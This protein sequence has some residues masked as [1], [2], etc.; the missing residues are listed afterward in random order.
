MRVGQLD[1]RTVVASAI[2][3]ALFGCTCC[4]IRVFAATELAASLS[5]LVQADDDMPGHV[6]CMRSGDSRLLQSVTLLRRRSGHVGDRAGVGF[7][8]WTVDRFVDRVGG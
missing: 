8:A 4:I 2:V 7:R 6:G 3:A 1:E 5:G